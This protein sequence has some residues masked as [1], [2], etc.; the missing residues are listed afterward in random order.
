MQTQKKNELRIC[1]ESSAFSRV[2][3]EEKTIAYVD[4]EITCSQIENILT[5]GLGK[6]IQRDNTELTQKL[7]Q[8]QET[9]NMLIQENDG[10]KF[11]VINSIM[12]EQRRNQ[13]LQQYIWQFNNC[14]MQVLQSLQDMQQKFID[15]CKPSLQDVVNYKN[16]SVDL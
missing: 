9:V 14:T 13:S 2:V 10:L 12:A 11:A 15:E 16:R 3:K 7:S 6:A 8:L 1:E 5:T 4:K